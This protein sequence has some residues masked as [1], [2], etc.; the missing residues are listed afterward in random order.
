[1]KFREK[2]FKTFLFFFSFFQTL[3]PLPFSYTPPIHSDSLIDFKKTFLQQ[4]ILRKNQYLSKKFGIDFVSAAK[5]SPRIS[6]ISQGI[7]QKSVLSIPISQNQ[8]SEMNIYDNKE[9]SNLYNNNKYSSFPQNFLQSNAEKI[10]NN[11]QNFYY[12]SNL[13]NYYTNDDFEPQ[14]NYNPYELNSNSFNNRQY[15]NNFAGEPFSTKK[16]SNMVYYQPQNDNIQ[17]KNQKNNNDFRFKEKNLPK[18]ENNKPIEE[19]KSIEEIVKEIKGEVERKMLMEITSNFSRFSDNIH[20]LIQQVSQISNETIK[21]TEIEKK[22]LGTALITEKTPN[23][24]KEKE[25]EIAFIKKSFEEIKRNEKEKQDGLN[26]S[27]IKDLI[28]SQ[29]ESQFKRYFELIPKKENLRGEN[30][31][32]E[33]METNQDKNET[34][35]QKEQ[36]SFLHR[37]LEKEVI[38]KVFGEINKADKWELLDQ[39]NPQ[40]NNIQE[41]FPFYF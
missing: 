26:V 28:N 2:N 12:E 9:I 20:N 14:Y 30:K 4:E 35:Y 11:N 24:N 37:E 15:G 5:N 1:M 8:K 21:S 6:D 19:N 36:T 29:I 39:E 31:T 38:D 22:M 18:N 17:I 34:L 23:K 10:K 27:V 13:R 7:L 32:I 33:K 41:Y 3:L 40:K 25:E 16:P